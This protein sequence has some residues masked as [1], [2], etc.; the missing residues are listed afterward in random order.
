MVDEGELGFEFVLDFGLKGVAFR[1]VDLVVQ[2]NIKISV[3]FLQTIDID[4]LEQIDGKF[5][6]IIS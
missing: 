2:L 3:F 6:A 4:V 1:A 5:Q